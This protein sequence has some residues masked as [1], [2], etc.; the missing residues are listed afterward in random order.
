MNDFK[1]I[2]NPAICDGW[3][4][5]GNRVDAPGYCKIEY[6][7]GKLSII[8]VI[9][10]RSSGNCSGSC[11]Q[12]TDEFRKGRPIN[13]WN[14]EMLQKFCDIWDE[15]HLNDMRP[16]CRHQKQLGWDKEASESMTLYHYKLRPGA[17]TEQKRAEKAALNHL[18]EGRPFTP[19]EDQVFYANLNYFLDVYDPVS[20]ELADYYEPYKSLHGGTEETKRRGWVRFEEDKRGILCKP[21][22][23]CGYKYG[24]SWLTEEV[25][26]DV[27]QWLKDLPDTK[28]QPAWV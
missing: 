8:G 9:G 25:P 6:K 24:S 2:V 5:S 26:E 28:R 27:L 13:E 14:E 4:R 7:D 22:P 18:K 19:T 21:C 20:G 17:E 15:W 12:C 23:V 10:P 1:K 11:G 16:Y 3:T